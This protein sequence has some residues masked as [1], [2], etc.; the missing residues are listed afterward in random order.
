LPFFVN[1]DAL[2]D[3]DDNTIIDLW[4]TIHR[5]GNAPSFWLMATISMAIKQFFG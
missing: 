3:I 4:H 1:D 2:V 5:W